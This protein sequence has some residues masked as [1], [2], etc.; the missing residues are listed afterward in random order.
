MKVI[1]SVTYHY[2]KNLRPNGANFLSEYLKTLSDS[3][4]F[5]FGVVIVDNQSEINLS[6]WSKKIP[7]VSDY[8]RVEDQSLTG[9]TGAWN[10]GIKRAS[11]LGDIIINTNED[12][13]FNESINTFVD[14]IVSDSERSRTIYGPLSNGVGELA[15]PHQFSN[16]ARDEIPIL[17]EGK[18]TNDERAGKGGFSEILNGF[19]LGFTKEFYHTF[20]TGD[21]LFPIVHKNNRGDGKWGGQEGLMIEWGESGSLCKII[22]K[23]WIDHAKIRSY[24]RARYFH[25]DGPL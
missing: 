14:E 18:C 25:G 17:L 23:C 2:S 21:D 24:R 22:P 5:N 7:C 20:K 8:I 19:F 10:V 11:E 12:L 1:F 15:H 6:D 13:V 9:L 16:S 3:A 4:K